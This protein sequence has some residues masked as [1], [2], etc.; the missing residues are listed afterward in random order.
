LSYQDFVGMS[1]NVERERQRQAWV[2][3]N[4]LGLALSTAD[5]PMGWFEAIAESR[6]EAEDLEY[7]ENGVRM[8]RRAKCRS[9]TM[10]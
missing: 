8:E 3:A 4:G 1:L 9:G 5:L 6:K 7:N 10:N 2:V